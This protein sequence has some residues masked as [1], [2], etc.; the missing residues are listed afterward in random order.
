MKNARER[1]DKRATERALT[2]DRIPDSYDAIAFDTQGISVKHHSF[3]DI[4]LH[5]E[6]VNAINLIFNGLPLPAKHREVFPT[7]KTA[8]AAA[9]VPLN[10]S[11]LD[12]RNVDFS[13]QVEVTEFIDADF[14]WPERYDRGEKP[15]PHVELKSLDID[16][17]WP[18]NV[19]VK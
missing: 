7:G 18:E 2:G 11:A 15:T 16:F 5:N 10:L 17:V 9:G 19:N 4:P 14:N 13:K 1:A 8:N 3:N 12:D 6:Q